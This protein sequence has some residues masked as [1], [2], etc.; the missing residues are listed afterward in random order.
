LF[1]PLKKKQAEN[2][3]IYLENHRDRIVN[4]DYYQAEN[5][6][7]KISMRLSQQYSFYLVVPML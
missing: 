5:I 2:I 7:P 3:C 6:C 1:S 4:Y